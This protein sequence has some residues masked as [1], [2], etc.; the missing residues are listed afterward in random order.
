MHHANHEPAETT[1]AHD[2]AG[3]PLGLRIFA[4]LTFAV[5]LGAVLYL[6]A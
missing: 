1:L 6:V 3:W 2:D 5:N 4:L